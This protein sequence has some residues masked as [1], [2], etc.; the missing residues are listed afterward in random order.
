VE[1]ELVEFDHLITKKK[2]E[3]GDDVTQIVNTNSRIQ[4]TA[5]A[6]GSMRHLQHGAII[7]LERRGFFF[8]DQAAFGER[9]LVLNYIPDGKMNPMSKLT[10]Q[11]DAAELQ[12]GKD[13]NMVLANKAETKKAQAEADSQ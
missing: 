4:Y 13:K 3:E 7:Q 9:K 10:H 11:I 8:V 1:V 5:I 12:K 2:I 6:E